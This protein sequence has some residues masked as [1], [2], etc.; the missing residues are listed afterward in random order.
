MPRVA[1]SGAIAVGKS[2][3]A[4]RLRDAHS[5]IELR[6][7][8]VTEFQFLHSFYEDPRR[9]AFHSRV[10]FLA[11]KAAELA[12][13]GTSAG[14]ITLF[15]RV[16]PELITFA[17]AMRRSGLLS[18][19]EYKVYRRVWEVLLHCLPRFDAIIWVRCDTGVCLRRIAARGRWYEKGIDADYLDALDEEYQ[20]WRD[21]IVRRHLVLSVDTSV[22][23][24]G[25][26][27]SILDW[28][29]GNGLLPQGHR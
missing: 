11:V 2:T 13:T 20:A 17:N 9:F 28:L 26:V 6:Q 3:L 5:S 4:G 14:V 10:E 24:P 12:G 1:L 25:L 16:L 8:D 22:D 7:E 19:R 21:A 18:E 23:D 27:P 15:D 29:S